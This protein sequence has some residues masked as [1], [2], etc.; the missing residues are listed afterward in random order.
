MIKSSF[1]ATQLLGMITG[2]HIQEDTINQL[3]LLYL[4]GKFSNKKTTT[5]IIENLLTKNRDGLAHKLRLALQNHSSE[6]SESSFAS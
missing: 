2:K 5:A 1:Q 4:S 6:T 3:A